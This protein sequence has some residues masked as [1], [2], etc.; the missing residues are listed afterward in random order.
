MAEDSSTPISKNGTACSMMPRNTVMVVFNSALP[1]A[2]GKAPHRNQ[3]KQQQRRQL[4]LF[5]CADNFA[6]AVAHD[7]C[8]PGLALVIAARSLDNAARK[9][10]LRSTNH[11]GVQSCSVNRPPVCASSSASPA[12]CATNRTRRKTHRSPGAVW[13]HRLGKERQQCGKWLQA[14]P[15]HPNLIVK[16]IADGVIKAFRLCGGVSPCAGRYRQHTQLAFDPGA[17]G[18]VGFAPPLSN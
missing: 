12:P 2:A 16:T 11:V 9:R 10:T 8:A 14:V 4:R 15:L 7:L 1:A 18:Q 17:A 13:Q 5:Q 6:A 3:R